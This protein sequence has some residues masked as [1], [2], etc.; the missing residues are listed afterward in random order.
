MAR[1]RWCR[2]LKRPSERKRA[3]ALFWKFGLRHYS[4]ASA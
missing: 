3:A 4:G 2:R 1:G